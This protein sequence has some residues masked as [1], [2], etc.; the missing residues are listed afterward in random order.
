MQKLHDRLD[1]ELLDG[2]GFENEKPVRNEDG[3]TFVN[4]EPV[5]CARIRIHKGISAER[6]KLG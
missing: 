6:F 5:S 1:G 3:V 4:G 2:S